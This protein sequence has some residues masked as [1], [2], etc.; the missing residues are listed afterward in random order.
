MGNDILM[1]Y[2]QPLGILGQGLRRHSG[3]SGP[4][5]IYTPLSLTGSVAQRVESLFKW[6]PESHPL[7]RT[8]VEL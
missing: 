8:S 6:N 2:L 5:S 4:K 1:N 7:R 3:P